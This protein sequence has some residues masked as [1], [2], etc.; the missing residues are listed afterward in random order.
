MRAQRS[1][2]GRC[3]PVEQLV[4]VNLSVR[5]AELPLAAAASEQPWR[6]AQ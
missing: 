4:R 5:D 2:N 3:G 6:A 1:A